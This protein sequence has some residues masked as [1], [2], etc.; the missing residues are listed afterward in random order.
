MES[1]CYLYNGQS[2]TR[3]LI[4]PGEFMIKYRRTNAVMSR[5]VLRAQIIT[6]EVFK[7]ISNFARDN[8]Y[9]NNV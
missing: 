8:R 2:K 1:I 7:N 4:G 5:E 9:Q 3:V 6:T